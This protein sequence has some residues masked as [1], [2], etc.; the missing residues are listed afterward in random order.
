MCQLLACSSLFH[1][2]PPVRNPLCHW[3]PPPRRHAFF[4]LA[5][6][7]REHTHREA[8][9]VPLCIE[10]CIERDPKGLYKKALNGEIK[11]FTGIDAPYQEPQNAEIEIKDMTIEKKAKFIL[12][13]LKI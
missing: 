5:P 7:A 9:T 4:A 12:N 8:H 11:G 13:K 1:L 6:P 2:S 10:K 3:T